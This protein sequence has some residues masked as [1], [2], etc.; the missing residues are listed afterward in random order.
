MFLAT[1]MV[2]SRR[3]VVGAI[4]K[5][6]AYGIGSMLMTT[7]RALAE[8]APGTTLVA[9][10]TRTGNTRVVAKQISRTLNGDLF[11][12]RTAESYPEDYFEMVEQ[13]ERERV[14]GFEPPLAELVRD[15]G[16]YQTVFLGFP[17]WG[18]TA[19]SVIRSFLSKHDLSGKTLIPFIT[20]GRYGVG[21]SVAVIT[22]HA[23]G[24][25][26]LKELS[27]QADQERDTVET[28]TSW[29]RTVPAPK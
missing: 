13:A 23:P 6:P 18:E 24:A 14:A 22:A 16:T 20:H 12:I 11:E 17:I 5:A 29:L 7:V 9:Y 19:P 21:N 8:K 15:I 25:R 26:L 27:M 28:V 2:V 1:E 10:M 3:Q 4:T